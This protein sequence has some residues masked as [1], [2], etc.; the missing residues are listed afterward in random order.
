M[1]KRPAPALRQIEGRLRSY[2]AFQAFP[3]CRRI[4]AGTTAA[5]KTGPRSQLPV[6]VVGLSEAPAARSELNDRPAWRPESAK[7]AG[8]AASF[9]EEVG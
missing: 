1:I 7:P 5:G 9:F 2:A 4:D 6:N 8:R 3:F